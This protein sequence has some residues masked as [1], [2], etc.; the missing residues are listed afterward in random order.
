MISM[1][2]TINFVLTGTLAATAPASGYGPGTAGTSSPTVIDLSSFSA[3]ATTV[4]ATMHRVSLDPG[5]VAAAG[6]SLNESIAMLASAAATLDEQ[7]ASL[8][9]A[10][11]SLG[12]ARRSV[13]ALERSIRAGQA[14]STQAAVAAL[15]AARTTLAS[16]MTTRDAL[17]ATIIE[18]A[19]TNLSNAQ[20]ASLAT[21]R[22]SSPAWGELPAA[23]RVIASDDDALVELRGALAAKRIA[24]GENEGVPDDTAAVLAQWA[25]SQPVASALA[26]HDA[27]A[28]MIA[29][30]WAT[31][32][33][34]GNP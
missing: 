7:A 6:V 23:Y 4:L 14:P 31:S 24:I 8:A 9:A 28:T 5:S 21:I 11:E 26:A 3:P 10:D 18:A 22:A 12:A 30:S 27:N 19:T 2:S 34:P 16:A 29:A 15:N 25:Q 20:K 32:V 1:I 13:D 33:Q 17:L